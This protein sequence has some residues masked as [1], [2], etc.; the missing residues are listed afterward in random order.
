[1]KTITYDDEAAPWSRNNHLMGT[2]LLPSSDDIDNNFSG[3]L[4]LR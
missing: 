2:R 1:M 3:T 4:G